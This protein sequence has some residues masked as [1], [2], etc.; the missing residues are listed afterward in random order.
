MRGEGGGGKRASCFSDVE[1]ACGRDASVYTGGRCEGHLLKGEV[2]VS[3]LLDV[4]KNKTYQ[5]QEVLRV[6]RMSGFG[7]RSITA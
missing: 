5:D 1:S 6:M 7:V 2:L 4:E 3:V